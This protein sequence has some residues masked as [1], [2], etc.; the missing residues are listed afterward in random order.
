MS[1]E[2]ERRIRTKNRSNVH[3]QQCTHHGDD[4]DDYNYDD[5]VKVAIK[6]NV[7]KRR[8]NLHT[9]SIE[10]TSQQFKIEVVET[11]EHIEKAK[12]RKRNETNIQI[13]HIDMHVRTQTLGN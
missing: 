5:G 13:L 9:N 1:I 12:N 4:D 6:L 11:K 7:Y 10:S 3:V 8:D 2:T